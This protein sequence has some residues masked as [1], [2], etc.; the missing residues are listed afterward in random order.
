MFPG[1]HIS[2]LPRDVLEEDYVDIVFTNEGVY[3]LTICQ[4]S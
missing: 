1:S 4:A 2:A 3:A